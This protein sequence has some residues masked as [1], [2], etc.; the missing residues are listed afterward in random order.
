MISNTIFTRKQLRHGCK[1]SPTRYQ[2][3]KEVPSPKPGKKPTTDSRK[4]DMHQSYTSLTTNVHKILRMH[5]KNIM[6]I[7]KEYLHTTT[8]AMQQNAQ[9]KPEKTLFIAGLSLCDSK[10]PLRE[11]DHLLP[12]AKITLNLLRSSRR[13]PN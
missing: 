1:S 12:Q 2:T 6:L 5:S 7:F 3:A 8:A 11:W 4:T 10:F 9:S 13:Q